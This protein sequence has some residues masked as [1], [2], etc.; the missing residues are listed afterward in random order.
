M[1]NSKIEN[2]EKEYIDLINLELKLTYPEKENNTIELNK[3]YAN[4]KKKLSE[5]IY[6]K[7][8]I[9]EINDITS[10]ISNES[11]KE[12]KELIKNE[13]IILNE[14][15]KKIEEKIL[16]EHIEINN[17][18]NNIFFEIRSA[19]GGNESSIFVKDLYK[20]YSNYFELK[21][22]K[23]E[24]LSCSYS[25]INGYKDV[26][27]NISGTNVFDNLKYESGIHRVQRVPLTEANGRVHTS[28]C[29]IAV[30]IKETEKLNSIEIN[31]NDL[32]IDTY[33]ASGAGGQHVNMTDSAVRI[34][35]IP[36]GIVAEC[37]SER[38]QHKNKNTALSLL[39]SRIL[40]I[41]NKEIK[42]EIDAKRKNLIGSGARSEKIRT[43]NF[44][45][46]RITD[47]RINLTLYRLN[48]VLNGN[49]DLI[50]KAL[51]K[52]EELF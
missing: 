18:I 44:A 15:K 3:S 9:K 25:N 13:L 8:I 12:L 19:S 6:Y 47:H 5:Y 37:Q 27:M 29:T 31:S 40:H 51:K 42:N 4:L 17:E 14:K 22:W 45:Q 39:K 52:S 24:T 41:K 11:E 46:N 21:K 1:K 28:T 20:M 23:Y 34:T 16:N 43:Y 7:K 26:I 38:S 10:I 30:L 35:H 32:R 48:D 50:I 33:R 2:L 49:I 36:T